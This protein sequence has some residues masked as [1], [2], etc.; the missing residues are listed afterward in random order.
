MR[1]SQ[2]CF[3]GDSGP[4]QTPWGYT[5]DTLSSTRHEARRKHV[6]LPVAE[7][8]QP[9]RVIVDLATMTLLRAIHHATDRSVFVSAH[10]KRCLD[11]LLRKSALPE[12]F[13][14]SSSTRMTPSIAAL[15]GTPSSSA[16]SST[17]VAFIAH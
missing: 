12:V 4:I 6:E 17:S 7:R 13:L 16:M 14:K 3:Q 10:V 2:G 9:M 5:G 1:I 8:F 11:S 15:V